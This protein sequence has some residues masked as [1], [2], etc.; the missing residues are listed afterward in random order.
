MRDTLVMANSLMSSSEL[1]A[2]SKALSW[3]L[4][5]CRPRTGVRSTGSYWS[6]TPDGSRGATDEP[7]SEREPTARLRVCV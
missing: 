1:G 2:S 6:R 4:S 3:T 5:N 7:E